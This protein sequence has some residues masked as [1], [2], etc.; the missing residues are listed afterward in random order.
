MSFTP[1]APLLALLVAPAL[2]AATLALIGRPA[3][4]RRIVGK[5]PPTALAGI[6]MLTSAILL[7]S[8]LQED[9]ASSAALPRELVRPMGVL[10][11]LYALPIGFDRLVASPAALTVW[12]V[13]TAVLLLAALVGWRS[14]WTVPAAALAYLVFGGILRQYFVFFHAGAIPLYMLAV[15]ALTPCADAWSLDRRRR[16]AAGGSPPDPHVPTAAHAWG[17]YA[18]W[19]MLALPYVASGLSKLRNGGLGWADAVNMRYI[20]YATNLN[21]M[22][23]GFDWGLWLGSAP[24]LVFSLLAWGVIVFELA[25]GLVLVSALARKVLPPLAIAFHVAVL[26]LQNILF[27]DLMLLQLI[28]LGPF[29]PATDGEVRAVRPSQRLLVAGLITF[30]TCAWIA[31]RE[32]YPVTAMQMFSWRHRTPVITY[33]TVLA[34]HRSGRTAPATLDECAYRSA[35]PRMVVSGLFEDDR[36]AT[37]REFMALCGRRYNARHPDDPIVAYAV[38]QRRWP[39]QADPDDP[40]RGRIVARRDVSVD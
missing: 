11:L 37:S 24:D 1:P 39:F 17:R 30:L 19:V 13:A 7:G 18:C 34:R 25:Y 26:F 14:R 32:W 4:A 35:A 5:A 2:L 6:R 15:L 29:L 8:V 27:L 38:E 3:F 31:R 21:T 20:Y 40:E 16:T 33:H 28:F 12:R 22:H 9:L 23:F 36:A 10:Q